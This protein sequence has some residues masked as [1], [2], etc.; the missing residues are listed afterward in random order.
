MFVIG[1]TAI[2]LLLV[3]ASLSFGQGELK[4]DP[5]KGFMVVDG[6]NGTVKT[7]KPL[8]SNDKPDIK[9]T[10]AVASK[11]PTPKARDANDIQVGR[12][13]D[14]PTLYFI[15]GQE[16]YKNNDFDHAL[17]NFKYADSVGSNPVYQ[18]WIGKAYRSLGKPEL[19]VP[20]MNEIVKKHPECDVA[21]DALLELAVYYQ[22]GDDYDTA[23]RLYAQMAEQYPFGVSYTTGENM[24][25]VVKEQRKQLSARLNS[26]LAMLGFTNEDV[27]VNLAAFQKSNRLKESGLADKTTVQLLKKSHA[28]ILEREEQR[29]KDAEAA[30]QRMP[31][32]AVAGCFGILNILIASIL[33]F[34]ARSRKRH[35]ALL[36]ETLSDLDVGKL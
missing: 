7:V 24:I 6:K 33:F 5:D 12:K 4:Y 32:V 14:P 28:L 31:F 25:D 17:Q 20:I 18:L 19:M 36:E 8:M 11:P 29:E 26:M 22:D 10:G 30:K 3:S 16:Y 13:K 2:A 34:Q 35:L 15:S 1:K 27:S 9:N 23:A 21:D